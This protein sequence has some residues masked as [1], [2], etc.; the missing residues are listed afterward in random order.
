MDK[1]RSLPVVDADH[2]V[3]GH[4]WQKSDLLIVIYLIVSGAVVRFHCLA[5][6]SLWYDEC[7]SWKTTTYRVTEQISCA[8]GD[9]HPPLYFLLL[10]LWSLAWGRS[11][12]ALRSLSA[13]F[14]LL[15]ILG[16]YTL[17]REIETTNAEPGN[18]PRWPQIAAVNAA[19]LVAF[20]PFQ[21]EWSQTV[22]MYSLATALAAWSTGRVPVTR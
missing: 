14:G 10:K 6:L 15:T 8:A 20:S 22:R 18:S 12:E 1:G 17:V 19:A 7:V 9:N 21:I 13:V 11:A 3:R 5:D 16:T 2:R 4:T